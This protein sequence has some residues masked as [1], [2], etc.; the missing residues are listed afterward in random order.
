LASAKELIL[1]PISRS[2]ADAVVRRYH[3]SGKVVPN[4]QFHIGVFWHGRL[5]GAMQFGPSLDKRKIQGIVSGTGW[6]DFIE[7]NRMAF[8]DALPRNSESRAIAIALR[9][10]RKHVPHIQWIVSFADGAQCGDG[11]IYRAAGFVLTGIRKNTSLWAIP[12]DSSKKPLSRV[13]ATK[14]RH[15]IAD[16]TVKAQSHLQPNGGA[17]MRRYAEM[18]YCPIAGYQL[19]YVYFLD[20]TAQAR[21]TVPILPYSEIEQMGAGMYLGEKISR[22]PSIESDAPNVQLGEGGAIPTGVLQEMT[23]A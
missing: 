14:G 11:A 23:E 7:L 20:K 17:S 4:S 10:L 9:L 6:N 5:E 21:L 3:Y 13:S 15:V 19:R 1:S 12:D 22:A 2:D 18:G 8:S 16:V